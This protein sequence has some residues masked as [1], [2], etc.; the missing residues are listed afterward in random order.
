[1]KKKGGTGIGLFGKKAKVSKPRAL[2]FVDYEHWYISL[3]KMYHTR[4]DIGK[5]I[6]DMK[7]TLDIRGIWFFGDFSKN[8]SLRE[9]MT[10]IRGFT[11]NIIETGNGTN[12]VTKDFTDFIMLDHIY[13]AAMSDRDDIDVFVIFTG[14]GH[15]TSVASFLKNKCKKEVEIY[16]V[17]GGC[18]NQLRMAA[19]RT[20]EYPD[21]T[22]DKKQIFQLIFSALDKIE[23]S[24]SSKNMKPTFIKTVEAVSVQNN[25]PRKKVREAAQW[26]VDNGY[27]ERK[28]EKAFGKTIVT[29]SANWYEVA[30]AGLW[31]PE[32]K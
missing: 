12:R 2:A 1:M 8:Q 15:F 27:I 28:K 16:A 24:P 29:V 19:S 9:E 20:V 13:Q 23:H 26:L 7:K 5:W 3:D 21:E 11:N 22:D 17:K 14:D 25:L 32:K 6:N 18:S 30:K 10:K 31:T 4:P